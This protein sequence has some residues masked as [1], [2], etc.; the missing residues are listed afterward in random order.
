MTRN[1]LGFGMNLRPRVVHSVTRRK[2]EYQY[3]FL[4]SYEL[5]KTA[6]PNP[7]IGSWRAGESRIAKLTRPDVLKPLILM[8]LLMFFQQFSGTATISYYA[9]EVMASTGSNIDQS[10]ATI[11]YGVVRLLATFIGALLLRRFGDSS[12]NYQID[13]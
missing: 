12:S 6:R 8:T 9:Y 11:I 1:A 3:I 7:E 4:R 5:T 2:V 10:D 13:Q